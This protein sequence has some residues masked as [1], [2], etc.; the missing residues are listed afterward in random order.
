[1]VNIYLI[2]FHFFFFFCRTWTSTAIKAHQT[3]ASFFSSLVTLAFIKESRQ[4]SSRAGVSD[5]V[6]LHPVVLSPAGMKTGTLSVF[7]SPV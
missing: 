1:M 2:L 3:E 4:F 5:Y 6:P 7:H